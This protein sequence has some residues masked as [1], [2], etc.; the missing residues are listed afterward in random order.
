MAN[1]T[2]AATCDST[3]VGCS[4][5]SARA[6]FSVYM[7]SH[8]GPY[9][10]SFERRHEQRLF[11]QLSEIAVVV[12]NLI[13]FLQVPVLPLHEHI[14]FQTTTVTDCIRQIS[15]VSRLGSHAVFDHLVNRR[16]WKLT[17]H[18]RQW[19]SS[20]VECGSQQF[21][22]ANVPLQPPFELQCLEQRTTLETRE[23]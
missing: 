18:Q 22:F 3:T 21:Q 19:I 23:I 14:E 17:F 10:R 13:D 11:G 9:A 4:N 7:I 8:T 20:E 2:T 5:A 1:H 6:G 16:I 15:V 12:R